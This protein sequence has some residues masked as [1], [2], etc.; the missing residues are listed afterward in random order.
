MYVQV[1]ISLLYSTVYNRHC[2][3]SVCVCVCVVL[4]YAEIGIKYPFL[5]FNLSGT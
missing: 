1:K 5:I 2:T 3:G 4:S